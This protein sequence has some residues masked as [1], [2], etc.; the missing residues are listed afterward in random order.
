[1]DHWLERDPAATQS[2]VPPLLRF[3]GLHLALGAA[4]GSALVSV[5]LLTN[6]GGLNDLVSG[7]SEPYLALLLLYVFFG[8]TS[9][10]AVM[11]V[12][13]MSLGDDPPANLH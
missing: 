7:D 4:A 2:S 3:L 10:G 8:L 6:V 11:G 5:G 13:V 12:A 9:A 1:M